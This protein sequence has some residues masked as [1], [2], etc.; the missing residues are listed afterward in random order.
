MTIRKNT[1]SGIS[2]VI[3]QNK[4]PGE[5][6]SWMSVFNSHLALLNERVAKLERLCADAHDTCKVPNYPDS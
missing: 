2:P 3:R 4:Q 1:Y 5:A 6:E